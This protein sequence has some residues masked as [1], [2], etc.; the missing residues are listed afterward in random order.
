MRPDFKV[1][2]KRVTKELGN[3]KKVFGDSSFDELRTLFKDYGGGI[4][5]LHAALEE[6]MKPISVLNSNVSQTYEDFFWTWIELDNEE[7]FVGVELQHRYVTHK[8]YKFIKSKL[9]EEFN[10]TKLKVILK[11]RDWRRDYPRSLYNEKHLMKFAA[12]VHHIDQETT[13]AINHQN[14]KSLLVF[15]VD[16]FLLEHS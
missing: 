14:Q 3:D 4:I 11:R 5:D 16:I 6:P 10:K 12:K 7:F 2:A 1:V 8:T 9:L 13:E 15:T